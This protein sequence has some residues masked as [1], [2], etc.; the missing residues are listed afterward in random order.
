VR[1]ERVGVTRHVVAETSD[2]RLAAPTCPAG[3]R[4]NLARLPNAA[5]GA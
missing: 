3:G 4:N 1:S 5:G 2:G